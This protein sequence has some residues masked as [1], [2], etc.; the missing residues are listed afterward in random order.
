MLRESSAKELFVSMFTIDILDCK[1][2]ISGNLCAKA[3][4]LQNVYAF[5]QAFAESGMTIESDWIE[6]DGSYVMDIYHW[7]D[8]W[9][10]NPPVLARITAPRGFDPASDSVR[11]IR[12]R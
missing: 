11:P 7:C 6:C 3:P 2:T 1:Y 8:C 12:Q 10:S 5:V 4:T 9:F